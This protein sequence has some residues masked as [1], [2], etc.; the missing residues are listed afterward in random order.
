MARS[1]C[2]RSV[3]DARGCYLPRLIP[4]RLP[5]PT[6]RATETP[7]VAGAGCARRP[8]DV[9]AAHTERSTWGLPPAVSLLSAC[10]GG[11]G[12]RG[13]H[14]DASPHRALEIGRRGQTRI[15]GAYGRPRTSCGFAGGGRNGGT[16]GEGPRPSSR[17]PHLDA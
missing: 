4:Q 15:D 3:Q 6:L 11:F 16:H 5:T 7:F 8:A 9:P 2:L 14:G 13:Q 1:R 12:R 10:A 17:D